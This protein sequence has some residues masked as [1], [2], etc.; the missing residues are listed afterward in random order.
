MHQSLN[1]IGK[2]ETVNTKLRKNE[3]SRLF[4]EPLISDFQIIF[5]RD[6]AARNWLEVIFCYPGAEIVPFNIG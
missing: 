3:S 5:E 1:R 2:T 6:P 4:L